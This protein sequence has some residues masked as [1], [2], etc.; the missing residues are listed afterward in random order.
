MQ[1]WYL[2]VV[3]LS[4]RLS[5]DRLTYFY[6]TCFLK[7]RCEKVTFFLRTGQKH[8]AFQSLW[9]TKKRLSQTF[10]MMHVPIH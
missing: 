6:R 7:K 8:F 5:G 4:S 3:K 10:L 2:L 9:Q 1:R